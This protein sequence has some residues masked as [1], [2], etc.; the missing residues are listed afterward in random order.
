MNFFCGVA[1]G[2]LGGWGYLGR[3]MLNLLVFTYIRMC[4]VMFILLNSLWSIKYNAKNIHI[5]GH[6]IFNFS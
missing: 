5:C 1:W 6:I 3:V 2:V 4:V